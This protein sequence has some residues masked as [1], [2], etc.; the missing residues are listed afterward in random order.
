M[1]ESSV[2]NCWLYVSISFSR[3]M[4]SLELN[5]AD[6]YTGVVAVS[7][8]RYVDILKRLFCMP[9]EQGGT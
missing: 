5:S 7:V 4:I 6:G 9:A 2:G 3:A 1:N 8:A